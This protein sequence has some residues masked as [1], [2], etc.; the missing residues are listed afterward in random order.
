MQRD[1]LLS[2]Y[3]RL[4]SFGRMQFFHKIEREYA[5]S[6]ADGKGRVAQDMRTA[7]IHIEKSFHATCEAY[8]AETWLLFEK[9][10]FFFGVGTQCLCKLNIYGQTH[11]V[12]LAMP[13]IWPAAS[14]ATIWTQ[15]N[16]ESEHYSTFMFTF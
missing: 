16:M 3:I 13:P 15:I 4:C 8:M 5:W 10:Y 12:E 1:S 11:C 9:K 14:F 2:F 7:P 6:V